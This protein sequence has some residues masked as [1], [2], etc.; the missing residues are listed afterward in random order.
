MVYYSLLTLLIIYYVLQTFF[1]HFDYFKY[2]I[3]NFSF[4]IYKQITSL[5]FE[6]YILRFET[7][8]FLGSLN[9]DALTN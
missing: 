5:L 4:L 7:S 8:T 9:R 6:Y 2:S 1:L 3:F